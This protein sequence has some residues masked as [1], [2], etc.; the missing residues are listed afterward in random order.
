M[1][2]KEK[3][4]VIGYLPWGHTINGGRHCDEFTGWIRTD[5]IVFPNQITEFKGKLPYMGAAT[6]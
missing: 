4:H 6:S 2:D 3:I 1:N 5:S